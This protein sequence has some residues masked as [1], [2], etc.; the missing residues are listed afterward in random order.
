MDT[1]DKISELIAVLDTLREQCPWDKKQT[2]DSLRNLTLEECYELCDAIDN[3]DDENIK[4][5]LGDLLLHI[6]FYAKIAEEKQLFN[7]GDVAASEIDKLKF[8]H[9]HIFSDAIVNSVDDVVDNWERLKKIEK[10][11]KRDGILDGI[12]N[13]LSSI[14]KADKIQGK[15][16]K[17][18][19]DWQKREQ[20]WD[21]V[22]EEL[23]EVK[24]AI[25]TGIQSDIEE[26]FGDLMFAVINASRLYGVSPET[27][28]EKANKKFINRFTLIEDLAK[29]QG[30]QL[31]KL[32]IEEMNILWE[33]AKRIIS[34]TK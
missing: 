3:S 21:K 4:E 25:N 5:E 17:I 34:A 6:L 14:L 24:E 26:E 2:N 7:I 19:F 16:A 23:G 27:A 11:A 15:V 33:K 32:D 9:P 10:G 30:N 29:Q 20:V 31:E 28:L 18:G 1:V 22:S 8:R 13:S 12:P